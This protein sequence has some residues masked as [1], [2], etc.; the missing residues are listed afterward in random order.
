M[1]GAAG[2]GCTATPQPDPPTLHEEHLW[3]HAISD[4]RTAIV[5]ERGA[6]SP[7]GAEVSAL[8]LDPAVEAPGTE[9]RIARATTDGDGRFVLVVPGG[10]SSVFRLVAE[11]DMLRSIPLDL[12]A[13]DVVPY[14]PSCFSPRPD[15]DARCR[16]FASAPSCEAAGCLFGESTGAA[17]RLANRPLAECLQI[18]PGLDVD[19]GSVAETSSIT[20]TVLIRNACAAAFSYELALRRGD[21]GVEI[22]GESG[23]FTLEPGRARATQVRLAAGCRGRVN[24]VLFI[25]VTTG[26]LGR[27][28]ITLRGRQ[29]RTCAA[30]GGLGTDA[31][32][33]DGG[34][35]PPLCA[36]P[37]TSCTDLPCCEPAAYFCDGETSTCWP[38]DAGVPPPAPDGGV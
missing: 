38:W 32:A 3:L 27:W 36:D 17:A 7:V 21:L 12:S 22:V 2:S 6:A 19:F 10:V 5:G 11:R 23:P 18:E 14:A 34:E 30:D 9:P 24:E 1:F 26:E 37:M 8:N 28:A 29:A 20:G 25:Q 13:V 31:G 33:A 35:A 15:E 4:D 16:A